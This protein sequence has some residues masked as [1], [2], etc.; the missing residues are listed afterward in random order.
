MLCYT[1]NLSGIH[2]F[3]QAIYEKNRH[4]KITSQSLP[5]TMRKVSS[6]N[7]PP[8]LC[9]IS[10]QRG[11]YDTQF[12]RLIAFP[13]LPNHVPSRPCRP[14]ISYKNLTIMAVEEGSV[15]DHTRLPSHPERLHTCVPCR[16]LL[17][18]CHSYC[19]QQHLHAAL[20]IC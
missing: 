17:F 7:S 10:S 9:D 18:R 6:Q 15:R 11:Q 8:L 16:Q 3:I 20:A 2:L 12:F 14:L 4:G 13:D 5:D 19:Y 1:P